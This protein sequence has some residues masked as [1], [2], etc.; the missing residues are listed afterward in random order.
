MEKDNYGKLFIMLFLSFIIMYSVMF[1][2]VDNIDNIYLNLNR[3]Y[4][5]ILMVA[6][7]AIIML[8]MMPSMFKNR[9]RSNI[10]IL[11]S[12]L[13]IVIAFTMLRSQSLI[14]DK[15]FMRSMIPH[16]SSA[17]LVSEQAQLEDPEVQQLAQQI[18]KSQK[19]EIEHQ[20]NKRRKV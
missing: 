11:S 5:S 15:A 20:S 3:L 18:I 1:F 10:I 17:I 6:P 14:G 12:V 2:N 19:E 9:K 8:L 13:V 7:M 4:M 16:H